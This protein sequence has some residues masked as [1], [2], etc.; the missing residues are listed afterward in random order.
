MNKT[1]FIYF[2]F[3]E[4]K[5]AADINGCCTKKNKATLMAEGIEMLN[6]HN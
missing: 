6:L 4:V 1:L 3:P 2:F 5:K